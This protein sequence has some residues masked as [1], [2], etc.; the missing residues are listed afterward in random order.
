MRAGALRH[1]IEIQE[2]VASTGDSMGAAVSKWSTTPIATLWAAIWPIRGQE[3]VAF[4]QLESKVTHKI[5]V[6]YSSSVTITP[7]NRIKYGSRYFD[8][9]SVINPDERNISLQLMC[10]ELI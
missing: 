3:Y 6:R 7:A 4:S 9:K 2:Q 5:I 1:K 10:E 8:I